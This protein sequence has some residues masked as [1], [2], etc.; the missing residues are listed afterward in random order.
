MCT[1]PACCQGI[2]PCWSA[3]LQHYY[4]FR[5]LGLCASSRVPVEGSGSHE[6]FLETTGRGL[7]RIRLSQAPPDLQ[8]QSCRRRTR[9]LGA[10]RGTLCAAR[11]L[12]YVPRSRLAAVERFNDVVPR[13]TP[14]HRDRLACSEYNHEPNDGGPAQPTQHHLTR[15]ES[16][17]TSCKFHVP[18]R[19]DMLREEVCSPGNTVKHL[20][21]HVFVCLV[22]LPSS[23]RV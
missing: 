20:L 6:A 2:S 16:S 8:E 12:L 18:E 4:T 9:A 10:L 15:G 1:T 13:M 21:L 11:L 14:F 17:E 22:G 19:C 3:R 7:F 5:R 23:A